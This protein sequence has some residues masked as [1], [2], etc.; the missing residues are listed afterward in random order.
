MLTMPRATR[1]AARF[2]IQP[3]PDG[4]NALRGFSDRHFDTAR[5]VFAA[6]LATAS[7]PAAE[8]WRAETAYMHQWRAHEK[9]CRLA[10]NALRALE[11]GPE[12][13]RPLWK[14]W[15]TERKAAGADL[16]D[17][18]AIICA[19]LRE[20]GIVGELELIALYLEWWRRKDRHL[21]E[22]E[23]NQRSTAL[24]RRKDIYRNIAAELAAT[25]H[26]L[27]LEDFD[28]RAFTKNATP[29]EEVTDHTHRIR[30]VAAPHE[31]RSAILGA[32]AKER[33]MVL[34]AKDTTRECH[35]CHHVNTLWRK[36]EDLVQTCA[37]CGTSWDQDD[38]AGRILLQRARE[39][40][41][42]GLPPGGARSSVVDAKNTA[43]GYDAPSPP[44]D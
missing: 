39:Q 5:Q 37:G 28:L 36:P 34:P 35:V 15:V 18:A 23:C 27:V 22:W 9:L 43:S 29:E 21:Y 40:S 12:T 31:L 24:R 32:W 13:V 38:N 7:G 3:L 30:T 33:T 42:G 11:I 25:Y 44:T 4:A 1:H 16:F 41:G 2:Q 10:E 6:W 20:R 26:T 14:D 8:W 17:G 19:W